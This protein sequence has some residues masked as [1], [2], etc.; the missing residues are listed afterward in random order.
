VSCEGYAYVVPERIKYQRNG[1][2]RG[3]V[4]VRG[5]IRRIRP[6]R[7]ARGMRID[8]RA[9]ERAS[10]FTE[11]PTEALRVVFGYQDFSEGR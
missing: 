8:Q 7:R 6:G 1:C 2:M 4:C 5:L 10:C 9:E 11:K 3:S